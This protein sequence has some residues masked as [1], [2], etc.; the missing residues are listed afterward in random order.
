MNEIIV[1]YDGS[2]KAVRVLSR[3]ADIA[4]AL[5][6][7]LVVVS[8][9]QSARL[10]AAEHAPGGIPTA[11]GPA[12]MPM[13]VPFPEREPQLEHM[14]EP[15]EIARQQLERARVSLASR[16]VDTEYVAEVGEPA[17]RLL[18]LAQQRGAEMIVVGS[19]E[20]GMLERLLRRGV[21]EAVSHRAHCD[22]LL[23]H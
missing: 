23:V 6:A 5:H 14:P 22:V 9:T 4:E 8:V 12:G 15:K 1:G 19:G 2:E 18:D 16:R 20:H 7:R 10:P 17:E 21:D 3:A 13:P 11:A